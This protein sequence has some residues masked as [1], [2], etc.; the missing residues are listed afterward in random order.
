[1]VTKKIIYIG[2]MHCASCK[3]LLEDEFGRIPGVMKVKVGVKEGR[4]EISYEKKMIPDFSEIKKVAEKFGYS[5]RENIFFDSRDEKKD[6]WKEWIM[7][8]V[9]VAVIYAV[10]KFLA[11]NNISVDPEK[12]GANLYIPLLAGLT[13]SISSCLVIVGSV[14]IAFGEKYISEGEN[15]FKRI[16]APNL[17]FHFGRIGS[18]FLLGG[19]LGIIGGQINISGRFVSFYTISIALVMGWL[20]FNILGFVP[21]ITEIGIKPPKFLVG[22]W[23]RIKY[24]NHKL[25]PVALGALSFFLPC[26][27]TQSMQIFALAS[28]SFWA[29]SVSLLLFSLGTMPMLLF[30]GVTTSF[31]RDRGMKISQKAAGMLIIAFAVFTFN[32]GLGLFEVRSNILGTPNNQKNSS[33]NNASPVNSHGS[34]SNDADLQTVEMHITN[35]GFNPNILELKKGQPAKWVIYGDQ[36]S[37][38]T[39]K[40]IVPGLDIT[41]NISSGPNIITFTPEK[42]GEIPFSCWMGMVRGKFIV[43]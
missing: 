13:A 3:K 5:C 21:S 26:G 15:S 6:N 18:F 11:K 42:S 16:L 7:A 17:A 30:L 34:I 22:Y 20:G 28:G 33:Q 29:G 41:Q 2:G 31:T 40:I 24:S 10:Y 8:L 9:A 12:L 39:G 38:C 37:S 25:A 35:S 1:M 4:A 23:D 27:F 19:L 32:S 36:I 43:R 14:V